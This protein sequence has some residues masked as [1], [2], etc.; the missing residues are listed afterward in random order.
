MGQLVCIFGFAHA[1]EFGSA[2]VTQGVNKY[3]DEICSSPRMLAREMNAPLINISEHL[4]ETK[5]YWSN[6]DA[7]HLG[8]PYQSSQTAWSFF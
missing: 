8:L 2:H 3:H 6:F 1:G 5:I 4:A 7:G